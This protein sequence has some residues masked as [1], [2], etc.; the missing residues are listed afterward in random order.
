MLPNNKLRAYAPGWNEDRT[1]GLRFNILTVLE[2]GFVFTEPFR[3]DDNRWA[4][5]EMQ[6]ENIPAG[7]VYAYVCLGNYSME[8]GDDTETFDRPFTHSGII[9]NLE[10]ETNTTIKLKV[11]AG[12]S[13]INADDQWKGLITGTVVCLGIDEPFN[14]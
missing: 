3:R 1:Q 13:D 8:F 6:L 14:P 9:F 2:A 4:T 11:S 5:Q 7:T 10:F 12:I